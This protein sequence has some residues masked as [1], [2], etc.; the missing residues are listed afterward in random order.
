VD[1]ERILTGSLA[2]PWYYVIF[3]GKE[4]LIMNDEVQGMGR[5]ED[6]FSN[7]RSEV[8]SGYWEYDLDYTRVLTWNSTGHKN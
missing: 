2:T 4:K 5:K 1:Y 3:E 7:I 6:W 8:L